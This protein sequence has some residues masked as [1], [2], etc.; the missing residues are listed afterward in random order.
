MADFIHLRSHSSY[1][2]CDGLAS[3]A[4]L[5]RKAKELGYMA[6]A[7]TDEANLF[8]SR[9]FFEAAKEQAIKPL[10][11]MDFFVVDD[12]AHPFRITALVKDK[13]GYENLIRLA[14]Y[15]Q[16]KNGEQ[17]QRG[18]VPR[19]FFADHRHGLLVLGGAGE[20]DVGEALL[21][22]DKQ[23]AAARLRWWL[24]LCGDDYYLELQ[25][26]GRVNEEVVNTE[27][28]LLAQEHS[29][30]VLATNNARFLSREDFD[31]HRLRVCIHRNQVVDLD[32]QNEDYLATQYLRSAEEM[33][34][35]FADL[36]EALENTVLA[37]RRCNFILGSQS[38]LPVYPHKGE[39]DAA[40]LLRKQAYEGIEKLLGSDWQQLREGEYERRLNMELQTIAD[41]GYSDYFLIVAD[42]VRW[43]KENQIAVGPGR[44]SGAGSLVSYATSITTLDPLVHNLFFE[45][46]LNPGRGSMP[47][48]DIDVCMERREEVIDYIRT[49]Y[50]EEAAVQII[51]FGTMGARAAVRDVTRVLNKPFGLGDRIARLIPE[52]LGATLAS[53]I[54]EQPDLKDLIEQDEEARNIFHQAQKLEGTVRHTGS[55]AAGLVITAGAVSD[56]CPLYAD[57]RGSLL[58]QL[59]KDDLE[60][61]GLVKFDV[62]GL[63]TLTVIDHTIKM[64]KRYKGV[65]LDLV[66]LSLEDK[67]TFDL[68]SS[69]QTYA[70]FQL[71]SGGMRDVARQMKPKSFEDIVALIALFRPG[72]MELIEDFIKNK[73]AVEKGEE[74]D[75]PHPKLQEILRPTYG[76]PV[77]QEQIMQMAQALA[78]FSLSQA[79]VL[80]HAMGKKKRDVMQQQQQ[81]FIEGAKRQGDKEAD[82]KKLF[83]MIEKFAGY[84]FNRSHSVGYALLA[85]WTAYLKTH[86]PQ[87]FLAAYMTSETNN[88]KKIARLVEEAQRL[89]VKISPPDINHGAAEFGFSEDGETIR[90]GLA[91]V[92]GV[93][94]RAALSLVNERKRGPYKGFFDFCARAEERILTRPFL[95]N[96]VRAGAFH[97]LEPNQSL[98]MHNIERGIH[99]NK[100]TQEARQSAAGDMFASSLNQEIFVRNHSPAPW[101]ASRRLQ[102][103]RAALG[104]CLRGDAFSIYKNEVRRYIQTTIADISSKKEAT[105]CGRIAHLRKILRPGSRD[106]ITFTLFDDKGSL[107]TRIGSESYE[108]KKHLLSEDQVIV[109]KG[110]LSEHTDNPWLRASSIH[111]LEYLR[112]LHCSALCLELREAEIS[113]QRLQLLREGLGVFFHRAGLPMYLRL[114]TPSCS[115]SIRF[116]KNN[117]IIPSNGCMEKIEEIFPEGKLLLPLKSAASH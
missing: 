21:R 20:G 41:M 113:Q 68:I 9:K 54:A 81:L 117:H 38:C 47:D 116:L 55:H 103:E 72:P 106:I 84:G 14:T 89:K 24:D 62:L 70:V 40:S 74:I 64:I 111:G 112:V 23:T 86:Y 2:I 88:H 7:L 69:A 82:A 15:A 25:R 1:S 4:M 51:S 94:R 19:S 102:E 67:A 5:A 61:Q 91:A 56:H 18:S 28:L 31:V 108:R 53:A 22:N 29:C 57:D 98:L 49:T 6:L 115:F 107:I 96:L 37:A 110:A 83:E 34:E 17:N 42:F 101:S 30:P 44:G 77:Y 32:K 78:G 35:L 43:A 85:Y 59:D 105:V 48:F 60:S 50:G 76:I 3:P 11:G 99:H 75:Y 33:K 71:E 66:E 27:T 52:T 65:D 90:Y 80:R 95:E 100:R 8:A 114:A 87:Y 63:R 36:P 109:V 73:E 16:T 97:L 45:R 26:L 93:G 79:D 46:F 13:E 104:F 58:T 92:K 10:L 12:N 39:Q